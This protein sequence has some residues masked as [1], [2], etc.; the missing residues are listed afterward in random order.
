MLQR[1]EITRCASSRGPTGLR[2]G[3]GRN[4]RGERAAGRRDLH[5]SVAGDRLLSPRR[6]PVAEGR[7]R[8]GALAGSRPGRF[9]SHS[10]SSAPPAPGLGSWCK[11]PCRHR[12]R[13]R[14]VPR[15]SMSRSRR[16]LKTVWCGSSFFRMARIGFSFAVGEYSRA[17][18]LGP[19]S[20]LGLARPG[21]T[22]CGA[23]PSA[24]P[25]RRMRSH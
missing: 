3:L 24:A 4:R 20:G 8:P 15:L 22:R 2:G 5:W 1:Q 18:Q 16:R 17:A 6:V 14:P 25:A 9:P 10:V 19:L 21:E 12:R 7:P 11:P 23:K 13:R